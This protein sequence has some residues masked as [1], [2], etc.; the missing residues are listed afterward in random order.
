MGEY[1]PAQ[2]VKAIFVQVARST[3]T[4]LATILTLVQLLKDHAESNPTETE[5][6]RTMLGEKE[7]ALV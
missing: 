5:K 2:L 6:L 4:L 3:S 1:G 7:V